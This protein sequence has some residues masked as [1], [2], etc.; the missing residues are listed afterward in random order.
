[1]RRQVCGRREAGIPITRVSAFRGPEEQQVAKGA[2]VDTLQASLVTVN[3][4][5]GPG[6]RKGTDGSGHTAV[7]M[8]LGIL[9]HAVVNEAGLAGPSAAETP[10][11]SHHLLDGGEFEVIDGAEPVKA[12]GQE[13]LEVLTGFVV[14]DHA[15]G[16]QTVTQGILRRV[17]F[18]FRS[19]RTTGAGAVGPR[20]DNSLERRHR[21]RT[22]APG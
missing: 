10:V 20:G 18:P 9:R 13:G 21:N 19:D 8:A 12:L 15:A 4:A 6:S 7:E 17:A 22:P 5:E 2:F 14:E 11:G 1:M 3:E 16:K